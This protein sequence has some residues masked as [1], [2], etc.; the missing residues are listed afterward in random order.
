MIQL[1]RHVRIDTLIFFR[2]DLQSDA[3]IKR[4]AVKPGETLVYSARRVIIKVDTADRKSKRYI[5]QACK[6]LDISVV[7]RVTAVIPT[8]SRNG[9]SV[10]KRRV[11]LEDCGALHI[12]TF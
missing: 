9:P 8:S 5:N 3:E 10:L 11:S 1:R 4:K 7:E 12:L 6:L 2:V